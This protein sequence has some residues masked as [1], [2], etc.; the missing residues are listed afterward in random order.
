[1]EFLQKRSV[2]LIFLF[3]PIFSVYLALVNGIKPYTKPILYLFFF[4]I[5][6]SIVIDTSTGADVIRIKEA[7]DH[8]VEIRDNP[9]IAFLDKIIIDQEKPLEI[10]FGFIGYVSSFLTAQWR[11]FLG[12]LAFIYGYFYVNIIVFFIQLLKRKDIYFLSFIIT[13]S[14]IH[15][16]YAFQAFRFYSAAIIYI[17]VFI[18]SYLKGSKNIILHF[19]LLVFTCFM[20]NAFFVLF[21]LYLI[22]NF[23]FKKTITTLWIL[24][25]VFFV[26]SS[27][28]GFDLGSLTDFLP[29]ILQSRTEVYSKGDEDASFAENSVEQLSWFLTW[30]YSIYHNFF[31]IF[32]NLLFYFSFK[33]IKNRDLDN[34]IYFTLWL[35]A[36]SSLFRTTEAYRYHI[37]AYQLCM[38]SFFNFFDT[39]EVKDLIIK[40]ENLV[41]WPLYFFGFIFFRKMADFMSL[42]MFFLNPLLHQYVNLDFTITNLY[43]T[44]FK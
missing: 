21:F 18:E 22:R 41:R 11:V 17:W 26:L 43:Q 7:F 25:N 4:L 13:F 8:I 24:Y 33:I 20:H 38:L 3:S 28:I 19:T 14:L 29:E 2:F 37:I 31:F 36:I 15:T 12:I 40:L 44:I 9:R 6:Y 42:F 10:M 16:P 39:S 23:L 5:G 35:V 1:M 34:Y 27:I 32:N 30:A